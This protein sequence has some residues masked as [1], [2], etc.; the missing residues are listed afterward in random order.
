MHPAVDP[1]GWKECGGKGG[2]GERRYSHY[3]STPHK[4]RVGQFIQ[5]CSPIYG[6]AGSNHIDIIV[7]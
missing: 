4:A 5:S 7:F 3:H 6:L 2:G 1:K